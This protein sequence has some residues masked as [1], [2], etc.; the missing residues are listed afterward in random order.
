MKFGAN[1]RVRP[2]FYRDDFTLAD[3]IAS[4]PRFVTTSA[5][6]Q[7]AVLRINTKDQSLLKDRYQEIF[8]LDWEE[9]MDELQTH[10]GIHSWEAIAYNGQTEKRNISRFAEAGKGGLK[11][12]FKNSEDSEIA[13]IWMRGSATEPVFRIMA[14]VQGSNKDAERDLLDWQRKMIMEADKE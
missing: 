1:V 6:S 9:R 7:E 13:Y 14:D 5:Y 8:I 12:L 11:I 3:I 2:I 10:Y 4:L